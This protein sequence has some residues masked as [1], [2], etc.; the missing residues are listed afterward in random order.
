MIEFILK[1]ENGLKKFE[2]TYNFNE[3]EEFINEF[4]NICTLFDIPENKRSNFSLQLEN[5]NT[6]KYYYKSIPKS[7]LK[8]KEK[9]IVYLKLKPEI[10]AR[11]CITLIESDEKVEKPKILFKLKDLLQDPYFAEEFISLNGIAILAKEL[12]KLRGNVQGYCLA[13]LRSALIYVSALRI[14]SDSPH[15]VGDIYRLT[16]TTGFQNVQI[17]KNAL[18]LMIVFCSYLDNGIKLVKQAAKK[19]AHSKGQLLFQNLMEIMKSEDLDVQVNCITLLNVMLSKSTDRQKKKLIFVWKQAGLENVLEF[20]NKS[21][22]SGVREQLGIFQKISSIEIPRSWFVCERFKKEL[23]KMTVKYEQ[24]QEK[25]FAYQRQQQMV[26]MLKQELHRCYETINMFSIKYG[27]TDK[28]CTPHRIGSSSSTD[29]VDIDVT[30]IVDLSGFQ[31]QEMEMTEQFE[32]LQKTR[33]ELVRQFLQDPSFEDLIPKIEKKDDFD[34]LFGDS[35]D[36]TTPPPPEENN[37]KDKEIENLKSEIE[38]LQLQ[39]NMESQE[40]EEEIRKMKTENEKLRIEF[41]SFSM[42]YNKTTKELENKTKQIEE[43]IKEIE[44]LKAA[45]IKVEKSNERDIIPLSNVTDTSQ[46]N[47]PPP[48]INLNIPPPLT[49]NSV[50]QESFNNSVTIPPPPTIP[51]HPSTNIPAPPTTISVIP[52]PPGNIPM[53]PIAIPNPPISNNIPKPPGSESNIPMPPPCNIPAP[54]TSNPTCIIPMPP[55]FSSTNIPPPPISNIPMPPGF[56]TNNIPN[57]PGFGNNIPPVLE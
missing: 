5:G 43:M 33:R 22:F 31:K 54:P 41:S 7:I 10:K 32:M 3:E 29:T 57:P 38:L 53:P 6:G 56:G 8:N 14:I 55:G 50:D 18:E 34:T 28:L 21:E 26:K 51:I 27:F 23:D 37:E 4:N 42:K 49:S 20:V 45:S 30:N 17:Y 47:I 24:V 12:T 52:S 11:D 13:S 36:E 9:M 40:K 25:L 44:Q 48:P 39:I 15:V 2:K 35:D 46:T 16:D 1:Y 19:L